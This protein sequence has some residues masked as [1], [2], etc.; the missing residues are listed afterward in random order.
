MLM[1]LGATPFA[2]AATKARTKTVKPTVS[3]SGSAI[4]GQTLS[5]VIRPTGYKKG[6]AAF[7]RCNDT[8]WCR[9]N[10]VRNTYRLT[11]DDV[12]FRIRVVLVRKGSLKDLKRINNKDF[13]PLAISAFTDKVR[14]RAPVNTMLP[15]I[16]GIARVGYL[17]TAYD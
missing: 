8:G 11:N 5:A 12:G 13:K 7:L 9:V 4:E 15:A 10:A 16:D 1:L 14:G 3:I 2:H 6:V 17:L